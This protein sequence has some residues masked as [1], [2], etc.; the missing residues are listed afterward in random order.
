MSRRLA[1]G[2]AIAATL[3]WL[4]FI[5]L[6]LGVVFGIRLLITGG[7]VGCTFSPDPALCAAVKDVNR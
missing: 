4:V 2:E 3:A 7:D 1:R 5:M 6:I